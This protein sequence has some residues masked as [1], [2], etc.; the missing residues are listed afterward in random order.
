MAKKKNESTV[1][2][3]EAMPAESEPSGERSRDWLWLTSC[4]V[5]T[6]L[7]TALRFASLDLKPFHHDEGVNGFFLTDLFRKGQYH[8]DP[9]NYHGPTLYYIAL[10]FAKVFG[11][12]TVPVRASV[13]VWGVLTVVL[14]FY[15]R[16]YIGKTASLFAGLLIAVSPGMVFISR[17]FIHETFFVF[18]SLAIVVS[19]AYFIQ[20]REAGIV[21][22]G[23]TALILLT[24][25][26]PSTINLASVVADD[27]A[28][29]LWSM[30]VLFFIV[31]ATLVFFVVRMLIGWNDGRPLYFLLAAACVALLFATKE[32][33][34]ITVG[35]MVIACI[36]VWIWRKIYRRTDELPE[37]EIEDSDLTWGNF[38]DAIGTRSDKILLIVA[39][40]ALVTYLI[41]LFFSSFFTYADGIKG[42]FEAYTIWT[43][44]GSK[45][46]TQNGTWAYLRWGMK[47]E[48]PIFILSAVGAIIAFAKSR[49][50]FAIFTA[51]WAFGMFAAYTLIPYK[52][53]WLALSFLM[54]MCII[55]GYGIGQ[56]ANARDT[57]L[58]FA[59]YAVGLAAA[60][61]MTY[62]TYELNFVRYD[63]DQMPYV[64]A[65][66]RRGFLDL[67]REIDHYAEKSGKGKDAQ[68]E[69]V[70]PDY[71][72]MVWYTKDYTH[73]N[74]WGHVVDVKD[75]EMIVAKKDE[76][77]DE[78]IRKFS[79]RYEYVGS[80]DLRPGVELMLLVRKDLAEPGGE[81]LYKIADTSVH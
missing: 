8:Y 71:W 4:F 7:A 44:T 20:Q 27:N 46:H 10:A 47:I 41:V 30:R 14:C 53:P 29:L 51:F 58:R 57:A 70:S 64:Y 73:A 45:D 24:C 26:L 60:C 66:T 16:P 56:L 63:D 11:L 32:T 19:T 12:E 55:A 22:I 36:C 1:T 80:W 9:A 72:P 50:R 23:W 75:S 2:E 17:Y 37:E 28:T 34:F 49:H 54:P 69:I 59:A 81:E 6:V 68:I 52:T 76:Q 77:D 67:M 48:A 35:T 65:H 33:A 40:A 78:V 25:F 42:F 5:V 39:A 38:V 61:I 79:A 74:Y 15:L 43:K 18:L 62:Q 31:E 3:P 21:G 13:A